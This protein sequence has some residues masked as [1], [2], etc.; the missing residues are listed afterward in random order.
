[1][2]KRVGV[3]SRRE[4]RK[5]EDESETFAYGWITRGDRCVIEWNIEIKTKTRE[6]NYAGR[7]DSL[8]SSAASVI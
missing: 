1:M 2:E 8:T 4:K 3:K 5:I 6:R 7:E